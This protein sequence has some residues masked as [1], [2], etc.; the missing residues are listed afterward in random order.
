MGQ[1]IGDRVE[2][3]GILTC[4]GPVHVGGWD[5]TAE[6]SLTIARDGTGRACLPGTSIAGALRA[7]LAGFDR[8]TGNCGRDLMNALFGHVVAERRDGSPSWIRVDDAHLIGD[9]V[10]TAVRD[11]VGIDRVSASAAANFLYTRQVLP[12]GTRFAFRV[13]ADTPTA[14]KVPDYP[15]GWR[16]LVDDAVEAMVAGLTNGRIPIGAGRGRGFGRVELREVTV[17]RADLS[18]PVGLVSWL[19]G[20]APATSAPRTEN[21]RLPDGRLRVT[22]AWRPAGPLLVRDSV[23]GTVVDTLPLTDTTAE[24]MVRLLLPGSSIR[25]AVRGYAERI[26]R[27]LQGQDAPAAFLDVLRHPPPGVDVLFGSAPTGNHGDRG[28]ISRDADDSADSGK[29]WRGVLSVT[30]CHSVG[31]ITA[32]QW[33]EIVAVSPD[34]AHASGKDERGARE[35][36]NSKRD[37]A[38]STLLRGKLDGITNS[39]SLGVSDHVAIDRWTGGAGEHRL[40]S[41]LD[42]DTS[43][44]WEP[45]HIE[46]DVTRLD[47][48]AASGPGSATLALPLLLLVLRDLRDGWLSLGYGGTRGR[49]QIDVTG[50]TFDGS[51]LSAPWQSLAGHTLDSILADPPS[52]VIEAMTAWADTFQEAAA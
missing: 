33:S 29:G 26:V 31:Q 52:E 46:V 41:V 40:F 1:S 12:A 14:A 38:R 21:T 23:S 3:L 6:A 2:V 42:P 30:D 10:P 50:V 32:E 37:Q 4:L 18:D 44:T 16:A 28:G 36:R 5:H 7:Y 39:F 15:G 34:A 20:T 13:V 9:D 19:T 47:R 48:S 43:V 51:G 27:T 11:G 17:R 35:E 24:G 45:I 49:G 25:G 8:F 22:I